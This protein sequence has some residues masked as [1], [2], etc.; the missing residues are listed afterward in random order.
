MTAES[1]MRRIH[2]LVADRMAD[3][4]RLATGTESA[5]PDELR[6]TNEE[7]A[8]ENERFASDVEDIAVRWKES[9]NRAG[10]A[11]KGKRK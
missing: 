2:R 9:E 4:A 1:A 8:D 11:R 10:K 3:R 5:D 7:T 6:R